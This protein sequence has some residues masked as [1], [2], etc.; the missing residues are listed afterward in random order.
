MFPFFA[1]GAAQAIEDAAVLSRCLA[2]D[3]AD[4]PRALRRY[5]ALRRPRTTR[6][7]EVSHARSDVDHL[8]DGPGQRARD[9]SFG[10][11]DPLVANAWIHGY[12]PDTTPREGAR[13]L[14]SS[15][16]GTSRPASTRRSR[17]STIRGTGT[18]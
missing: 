9:R 2:D 13:T 4:P 7:Q 14:R 15:T 16:C 17:S 12:D 3:V 11:S 6:L 8:P 10:D 5:E 18:C 1:Q